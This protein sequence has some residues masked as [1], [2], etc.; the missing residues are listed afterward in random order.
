[1]GACDSALGEASEIVSINPPSLLEAKKITQSIVYKRWELVAKMAL[2]ILPVDE[3][4]RLI[5]EEY[6]RIGLRVIE[7]LEAQV[8]GK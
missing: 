5:F 8:F 3:I 1:M 2:K 6:K 4:R 7:S